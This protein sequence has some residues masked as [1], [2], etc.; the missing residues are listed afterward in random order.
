VQLRGL[1]F[2]VLLTVGLPGV[3]YALGEASRAAAEPGTAGAGR[4]AVSQRAAAPATTQKKNPY[5]NRSDEELA[6]MAAGWDAL[7]QH[8]RRFLLTEMK[9]RMARKGDHS[10]VI[11]IRTERRYGRIIRQP[12]G[13][14][15]HIET[16]VVHVR[17]IDENDIEEPVR[18][19]YGVGFE[20]RVARRGGSDAGPERPS[21]APDQ[22]QPYEMVPNRLLEGLDT[23]P[24]TPLL[25]PLPVLRVSDPAP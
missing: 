22:R 16:Q 3:T 23:L 4:P 5:A 7:G 18:Q 8:E 13:R 21:P 25:D 17:P 9:R 1:A 19:G 2:S 12:D 10:G 24:P 6:A 14:V 15:I 11:R 20:Q